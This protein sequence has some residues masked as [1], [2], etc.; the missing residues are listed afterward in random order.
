MMKDNKINKGLRDIFD[1]KDSNYEKKID[2]I[3]ISK[4][5]VFAVIAGILLV[6]IFFGIQEK[7]LF[8]KGEVVAVVNG[9]KIYLNELNKAFENMPAQYK[10]T[11]TRK[12][13]L[14][15]IVQ[16]KVYYREAI[17]QNI[18]VSDED[19]K[20][21]LEK[22]RINSGLSEE[23]FKTRVESQG[24]TIGELIDN[25][26]KQLT[27]QKFI[28]EKF[29]N[30]IEVSEDEINSYYLENINRFKTDEQVT[31]K[32]I[33]IGNTEMTN[34]EQDSKSRELL[35]QLN[36]GNFCQYV[37]DFS[38]DEASVPNCGEYTFG[39]ADS[40]VEEFKKL[41]FEQNPGDMGV[42]RTQFGSHIIWTVEKIPSRVIDLDEAEEGITTLL[43][44]EKGAD[45][46]D[47]FY[48]ELSKDSEIEILFE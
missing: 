27:V 19:A 17:K 29:L 4:N 46:Y 6:L 18:L 24:S 15:Q 21:E 36:E 32:H 25:Y 37:E 3:K 10:G 30:T 23:D 12:S 35:S 41:S 14:N 2:S 9:E 11:V 42:V 20:S 39:R 43:K 40:Y 5:L 26:K 33:L 38:T 48:Q 28:D 47:S 34:E 16:S 1:M 44:A 7:N 8:N 22:I 45:R 31:V 13:L